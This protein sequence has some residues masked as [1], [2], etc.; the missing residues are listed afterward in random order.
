MTRFLLTHAPA[1]VRLMI[2]KRNLHKGLRSVS[3]EFAPQ[4]KAAKE[5]AENKKDRRPIDEVESRWQHEASQFSDALEALDTEELL[6]RARKHH[7]DTPPRP[8][9]RDVFTRES[10]AWIIGEFGDDYLKPEAFRNLEATVRDKEKEDGKYLRERW[11][12]WVGVGGTILGLALSF[13]NVF[14][15][16][17]SVSDLRREVELIRTVHH[18]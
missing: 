13:F 12:F 2:Q 16:S 9:V 14:V 10:G 6:K 1:P 8:V 18:P 5:E 15:A 17:K 7:I 3:D 4:L 11:Q